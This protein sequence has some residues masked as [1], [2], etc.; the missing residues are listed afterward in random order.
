LAFIIEFNVQML[1]LP[2]LQNV[3]TYFLSHPSLPPQS[4]GD[5]GTA[6]AT[7]PFYFEE[8]AKHCTETQRLLSGTSLTVAFQQAGKHHLLGMSQQVFYGQ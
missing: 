4:T 3:V 5:V 6:A 7:P 2:G 1:E 8:M